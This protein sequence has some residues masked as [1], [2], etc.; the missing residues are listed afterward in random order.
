MAEQCLFKSGVLLTNEK[1]VGQCGLVEDDMIIL[2]RRSQV[3]Q[4]QP[5]GAFGGG[6]GM[7]AQGFFLFLFS[8]FY[9]SV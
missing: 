9:Q 1:T 5:Q 2:E 3:A 7:A 4:Q 6:G 8:Y